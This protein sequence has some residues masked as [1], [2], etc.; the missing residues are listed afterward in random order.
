MHYAD[1]AGEN[2]RL[3]LIAERVIETVTRDPKR[4]SCSSG[5][6]A[7]MPDYLGPVATDAR[8]PHPARSGRGVCC[9]AELRAILFHQTGRAES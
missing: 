6:E 3:G 2:H 5:V 9:S 1:Q 7:G 4:I 8:G